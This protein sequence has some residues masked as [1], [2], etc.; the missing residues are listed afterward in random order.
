[1]NTTYQQLLQR[2]ATLAPDECLTTERDYNFKVRILPTVEK[3]N[4]SD[5]WRRVSSENIK[6]RLSTG[7]G[8]ILPQLN[9]VLLTVMHQCAV[10]QT[11]IQ[12]TFNEQ[13]T[14]AAI[15]RGLQSQLHLHPAIAALDAYVQLLQF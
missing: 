7:E 2:W 8:L 9:F 3:R 13:G 6:W 1:M 5:A 4:S 11:N 12:F 10:R 15:C 14:T